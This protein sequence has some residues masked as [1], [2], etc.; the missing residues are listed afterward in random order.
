[1]VTAVAWLALC[2]LFFG[3]S[4]SRCLPPLWLAV[5]FHTNT[6]SSLCWA[7]SSGCVPLR[8]FRSEGGVICSHTT[9]L[10]VTGLFS[11]PGSLSLSASILL[12]RIF[13]HLAPLPLGCGGIS[14]FHPSL[15]AA[16]HSVCLLHRSWFVKNGLSAG[17]PR[18]QGLYLGWR[19][20]TLKLHRCYRTLHD[21]S[22]LT[23][24][25]T[26]SCW[27]E[28]RLR[29]HR[30]QGL[31]NKKFQFIPLAE[32]DSPCQDF[33]CNFCRGGAGMEFVM[34]LKLA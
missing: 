6:I 26:C 19:F 18:V 15:V 5:L 33:L 17:L 9:P 14:T 10:S 27:Q 8:G 16:A 29:K 3:I 21:D 20:A 12:K 13:S 30:P 23:G 34:L 28:G 32:Q 1:M 4:H 24:R 7:P 2:S 25:G 11:S 31:Q 22:L